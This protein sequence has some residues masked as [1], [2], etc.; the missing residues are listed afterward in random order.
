MKQPHP[1][2]TQRPRKRPL[3]RRS[4]VCLQHH[5]MPHRCNLGPAATPIASSTR[6]CFTPI[7]IS[8]SISFS[9]YFASSGDALLS[10]PSTSACPD[11]RGLCRRHSREGLAH[12]RQPQ[13]TRPLVP[14]VA[15]HISRRRTHIPIPPERHPQLRVRRS[16]HC[17]QSLRQQ[18]STR[19]QLSRI[20]LRKRQPR[21]VQAKQPHV[22]PL[23]RALLCLHPSDRLRNR[24]PLLQPARRPRHLLRQLRHCRKRCHK[25]SLIKDASRTVAARSNI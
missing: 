24:R 22:V 6:L 7:R 14:V 10:K 11:R 13:V 21:Q 16:T 1:R 17:Q 20:R 25:P 15:Q 3:R 8:P 4:Q 5:R 2:L 19:V 23:G 12:L 18:R 9:R